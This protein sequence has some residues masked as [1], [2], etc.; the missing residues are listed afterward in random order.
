MRTYRAV[1]RTKRSANPRSS[2][3]RWRWT[4]ARRRAPSSRRAGQTNVG[5]LIGSSRTDNEGGL[6][7]ASLFLA[8]SLDLIAFK[9]EVRG[10]NPLRATDRELSGK[11]AED[12]RPALTEGR[13]PARDGTNHEEG[14]LPR[15]DVVRQ[16][17][18]RRLVRQILLA[19][20]EP[21]ERAALPSRAVTNG[22]PQHRIG[23][24]HC[25]E[26][27]ALRHRALHVDRDLVADV[28][29][30]PQ[31]MRKHD[32]DHRSVCT[33]TESTG[34]RSRTIGAPVSPASGGAYTWP[35]VVPKYTPHLSSASTAI[36]SRRTFT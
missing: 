20:E 3:W 8:A 13:L 36:A 7:P 22:A 4:R 17:C 14:F 12:L 29:E 28:R 2:T 25:V 35:P 30:R 21:D 1:W 10:S 18:I 6:L 9:E 26:D 24:L 16:G 19:R 31:M 11:S 32:A 34:G 23:R 5:C 33:S 15:G 27:G